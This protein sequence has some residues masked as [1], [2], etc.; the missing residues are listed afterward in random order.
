MAGR[1][2]PIANPSTCHRTSAADSTDERAAVEPHALPPAPGRSPPPAARISFPLVLL[3][4]GLRRLPLHVRGR[5]FS[6]ALQRN[7][8]IDGVA[9]ARAVGLAGRR[10]W[11]LFLEGA[12]RPRVTRDPAVGIAMDPRYG[13]AVGVR[14]RMRAAAS[15]MRRGGR[16]VRAAMPGPNGRHHARARREQRHQR[17]AHDACG[18]RPVP[19]ALAGLQS[20]RDPA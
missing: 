12:Q 16:R 4:G 6:A 10:A 2:R 18:G 13:F 17:Q 9:G 14:C 11:I 1:D 8:V 7:D 5:I 19:T 20:I 3:P 15:R